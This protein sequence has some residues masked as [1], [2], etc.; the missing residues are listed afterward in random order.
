[1]TRMS[2]L[3]TLGFLL[4]GCAL[5]MHATTQ[6]ANSFTAVPPFG[7]MEGFAQIVSTGPNA[8]AFAYYDSGG[9][10]DSNQGS[11]EVAYVGTVRAGH[12]NTVTLTYRGF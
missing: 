4:I 2:L 9:E 10:W 12:T 7:Y 3:L 1:M 11:I 8:C 6:C 5:P